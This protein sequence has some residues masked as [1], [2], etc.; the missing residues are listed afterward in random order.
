MSHDDDDIVQC[1]RRLR[2]FTE[3]T[4]RIQQ[5]AK[6]WDYEVMC[7]AW[8]DLRSL[9]R[10]TQLLLGERY[11][12]KSFSPASLNFCVHSNNFAWAVLMSLSLPFSSACVHLVSP[13]ELMALATALGGGSTHAQA[14]LRQEREGE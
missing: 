5:V 3:F 11:L 8:M 13:A 4:E 14:W 12:S 10:A 6:I 7:D 2:A 1:M 9:A